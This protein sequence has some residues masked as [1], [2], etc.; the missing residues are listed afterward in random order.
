MYKQP[1]A[2]E[3]ET[4][5]VV[6]MAPQLHNPPPDHLIF[7][8]IV[9]IFCCWP[10]GLFAILKSMAARDAIN[11]GNGPEALSLSQSAK[12]LGYWTLGVGIA[13][14]VLSVASVIIIYAIWLIPAWT[15]M[16]HY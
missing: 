11:R 12:R 9:T 10:I 3:S 14:M 13:F 2:S 8:V 1:G 15:K 5:M 7:N 4:P 16:S 6:V